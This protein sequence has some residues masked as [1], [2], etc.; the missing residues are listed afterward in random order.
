MKLLNRYIL[1]KYL[2]SFLFFT[3]ASVIIVMLVHYLNYKHVFNRD[4]VSF[5][6]AVDYYTGYSIFMSNLIAPVAVFLSTVYVTGKLAQHTEII[7]MLS[8][9]IPFTKIM[10]P[11]FIGAII[12]A[13][14]N[15][16]L[17]GWIMPYT[18]KSRVAFEVKYMHRAAEK[19]TKNIHVQVGKEEYAY[20]EHYSY[21]YNEGTN[22]T[23][24]K[25]KDGK[26]IEKISAKNILWNKRDKSW[27]L[28]EWEVKR[29]D[30]LE[31]KYTQGEEMEIAVDMV[32]TD[33]SV[34]PITREAL[35]LTELE[36]H[37]Q[38]LRTKG[39]DNI[40]SFLTEKH[41]RYMCPFGVL[42]LTF[43]GILIASRKMRKGMAIQLSVGCALALIYIACYYFSKG[44]A[45]S[46]NGNLILTVWFPNIVFS[47]LSS[48]YYR[49]VPK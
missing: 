35:T 19:R 25:V 13:T 21:Y 48:V 4:D 3:V 7:A 2:L 36:R 12:I 18:S 16:L 31:E 14:A 38:K 40:R 47:L 41:I 42:I 27:K 43:G 46:S 10:R 33:F 1:K 6:Q 22:F 5:D 9:G 11:Y 32:P 34:D 37:I 49:F 28:K 15:F 44:I 20:I 45:S 17:A 8:S 30:G 23:L 24:E 29:F 39:A 26:L